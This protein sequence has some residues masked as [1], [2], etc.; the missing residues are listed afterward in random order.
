L[1]VRINNLS[2]KSKVLILLAVPLAFQLVITIGLWILFAQAD[3]KAKSIS[4]S[5]DIVVSLG[6]FSFAF[7]DATSRMFS[8]RLETG[9]D[10]SGFIQNDINTCRSCLASFKR[11][12]NEDNR[13]SESLPKVERALEGLVQLEQQS[14]ILNGS[15]PSLGDNWQHLNIVRKAMQKLYADLKVALELVTAEE[16]VFENKETEETRSLN[17]AIQVLLV[18]LVVVGIAITIILGLV[19]ASD[20]LRQLAVVE[21]N[22]R[23]IG[24][25]RDL[26]PPLLGS[27]EIAFI[28]RSLHSAYDQLSYNALE[29][30]RIMSMLSHDLRSPLLVLRGSL[31]LLLAGAD[32]ELPGPA[33]ERIEQAEQFTNKIVALTE[34]ILNIEQEERNSVVL[35]VV[36]LGQI[37][38]DCAPSVEPAARAREV[39]IV[40]TDR[41]IEMKA[42]LQLISR[43]ITN[44]LSNAVKFSPVGGTVT[45]SGSAVGD[46]IRV[47]VRDCGVGIDKL[48]LDHIFE[49]F[50]Q[51]R[52]GRMYRHGSGLGLSI[53]RELVGLNGGAISVQSEKGVGTVFSV[54]LAKPPVKYNRGAAR[55]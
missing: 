48:E 40:C 42:D 47:D 36:S 13:T 41:D 4:H 50:Y 31:A 30:Q 27:N 25:R 17:I 16:K 5:K 55:D 53:C 21:E 34:Q 33:Q 35:A 26:M 49:P 46:R 43:V 54:L 2:L 32:G 14:K 18:S 22:A 10:K 7:L 52:S 28:D 9:E 3:A 15:S 38:D 23:R 39:H 29:R 6:M 19:F 11:A 24:L 37:F 20:T 12:V 44:L 8:I 45:V 1:A 51:T